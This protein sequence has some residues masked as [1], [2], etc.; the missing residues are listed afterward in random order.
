M[1]SFLEVGFGQLVDGE[2]VAEASEKSCFLTRYL[3]VTT[4]PKI[5][6]HRGQRGDVKYRVLECPQLGGW[7]E[8]SLPQE[9]LRTAQC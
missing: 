1:G 4:S 3:T 2:G 8:E 9:F 5:P 7:G 6:E